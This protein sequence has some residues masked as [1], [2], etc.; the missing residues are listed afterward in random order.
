MLS[1]RG[2]GLF[3]AIPVLETVSPGLASSEM[4][5]LVSR[6]AS[7]PAN[8]QRDSGLGGQAE[9]PFPEGKSD[10]DCQPCRDEKRLLLIISNPQ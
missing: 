8:G 3:W 1:L 7:H 9:K 10:A 5:L 4:V 6:Q 2:L